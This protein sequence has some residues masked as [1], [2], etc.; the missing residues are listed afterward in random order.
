[1]AFGTD[2]AETYN[3]FIGDMPL[4]VQNFVAFFLIVLV[5]LIYAI[6][7]WKVHRWISTKNLL[8]LNLSPP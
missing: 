1:M 4:W 6:F 8:K 5:V 2:I 3:L 7:I